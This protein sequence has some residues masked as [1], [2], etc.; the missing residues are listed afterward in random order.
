MRLA[1]LIISMVFLLGIPSYGRAEGRTPSESAQAR[2]QRVHELIVARLANG[3]N[4]S[5]AQAQK[6]G[7]V[8]KKYHERK[9]QLRRETRRLTGQLREE[10]ASGN[11]AAIQTT[12]AKLQETR[13]QLDRC[14]DLMYAEVKTMLSPKQLA[15]FV[16]I[17]DEIR[18]EIR[19]VRRRSPRQFQRAPTRHPNPENNA[20]TENALT[21][22]PR[23]APP[24][25]SNGIIGN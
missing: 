12:L 23:Q 25:L 4:L 18:H 8:L 9:H 2:R 20:P 19:A 14:D 21:R 7:D 10:T 3:L 6:L 22:Q 24:V 5:H 17:M 15:Q 11:K 16:L 13:D 1:V